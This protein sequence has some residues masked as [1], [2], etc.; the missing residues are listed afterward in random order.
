MANI[1]FL[2]NAYFAA[3]VGIGTDS[4]ALRLNV[5][6]ATGYPATSGTTQTGVFRVSGGTGLYNVI[7]MGV[8]ESTDTAWIQ[9]TRANNLGAN[10]KL[11]INPNGGSVGIGTD[12]PGQ[13]LDVNGI[14]DI[15]SIIIGTSGD[16]IYHNDS[17]FYIKTETAHALIFRTSNT[18][19]LTI[20]AGGDAIFT[21]NVGIGTTTPG[22]RLDVI[23]TATINSSVNSIGT[24]QS[25]T[26][27]NSTVLQLSSTYQE[28]LGQPAWN[29]SSGSYTNDSVTAPDGTT[30]GTSMTFTT[31]S[32][33]LYYQITG[34]GA[35]DEGKTFK[36]TAWLKL[37]TATNFVMTPNNG[38]WNTLDSRSFDAEDGLNTTTWTQVTHEF[39]YTAGGRTYINFH[40][41]ANT[42]GAAQTAGTVFA[43][44]WQFLEVS[45]DDVYTP[46][47][48]L[49]GITGN[50]SYL[51]A[52]NVGIGTTSPGYKLS[53][54]GN[55]EAGKNV[56]QDI[57]ASGGY[58]MRPWGADYLNS[59]TNVHTGAIKIILPT[60]AGLDD[61]LKF[62]VDIYQYQENESTSID[63]AGYIY[64]APGGNTWLNCT[65]I[66]HT[67]ESSENYTVR[68]GDDG[69]NHC[70]WIGEL[71][72]IWNY[73]QIIV[74]NFF[75]GYLTNTDQYLAE[76]EID[77]EATAFEDVNTTQSNNF[78]LSSGGV[79]GGFLPLSAGSTAPL[80]GDL[81]INNATYIRTTDSNGATPRTFGFNSSNN[82]YIGPIDSYAGGAVFYGVSA[83]VAS[84]TLYT[85]G[86]AR[87]IINS[88][89]NVGIGTTSPDA[90]LD[91]KET[92]SDVA[93]EIIVGG[94]IA[95][96]NV[97]F[98]KIS[99]ANTASTNTQTNDILA[100]I[101]GEKVGSSNRGEL[102]FSTSDSAAPTERMRI[103]S[104]G[105]VGIGTNNPGYKLDVSGDGRFTG[106]VHS[107]KLEYGGSSSTYL[108]FGI[109]S[110]TLATG[111][112]SAL[113]INSSQNVFIDAGS[114]TVTTSTVTATN[115]ILSSDERLKE[116]I[117][118]A[119]DNRI[120][121]DWK[122]FELKTEK[123]Q[124]RYGVIAQELEKTN[125][126]FVRED[127]QGFKSVAYIDLLI[128]KIAEL[129]ARLEKAGI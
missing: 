90:K 112:T 9:A 120:K 91:V 75:G 42:G 111:S 95:S 85:G 22:T 129:E 54:N 19:R 97:P 104:S 23:G 7:D 94:L 77:F 4:P 123:G 87:M 38:A 61:M 5:L 105:N 98:G 44:D 46:N 108:D 35:A 118:K 128:A 80:S 29:V 69:T 45:A 72:S 73:P 33:D 37:G 34:L 6:G 121:A 64:Q 20:E 89:G 2:N 66:V 27:L 109:N 83:N 16:N 59:T 88:S 48:K 70:I 124:K 13:L 65:T 79:N 32:Y 14:A 114:L 17:D 55:I 31:T 115:F 62:T 36:M 110:I 41:G 78:P 96:D 107:N 100:S 12:S 127:T 71:N 51:N 99:F 39:V 40:I 74:R 86:S 1:P 3:K 57:G 58:I 63:V 28:D 10:D 49:D 47:I 116:N 25:S 82:M 125:P 68:Y 15:N 8:N 106:T 26:A 43:W 117:E 30:T 18:N 119:R 56:F 122:T 81:Y 11:A 53:V 67:K 21:G 103:D 92:T 113:S 84:H 93:G 102:T 24:V 76:W 60:T 101:A 52:G 126:E 50:D